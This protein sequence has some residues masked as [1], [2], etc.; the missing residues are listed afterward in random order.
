M[1]FQGVDREIAIMG[2]IHTPAY[3]WYSDGPTER[4]SLVAGTLNV[5]S[6]YAKRYFSIFTQSHFPCIELHHK[7]HLFTAFPNLKSWKI[8]RGV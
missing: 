8:N 1:R 2:D 5:D 4:L 3:N 7:E 6:L